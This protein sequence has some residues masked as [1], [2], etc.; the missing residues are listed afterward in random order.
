MASIPPAI[1]R[2]DVD[3][4]ADVC[5][6]GHDLEDHAVVYGPC[7][8]DTCLCDGFELDDEDEDELDEEGEED[9]EDEEDEEFL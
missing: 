2:D 3:D 4:S 8:F 1:E 6:C 7:L 5:T 9:E